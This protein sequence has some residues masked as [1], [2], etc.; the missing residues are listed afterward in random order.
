MQFVLLHRDGERL[1][2]SGTLTAHD[3]PAL[4]SNRSLTEETNIY[5]P[6][7]SELDW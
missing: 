3:P 1:N 2:D 6:Y 5:V 7:F 4:Q